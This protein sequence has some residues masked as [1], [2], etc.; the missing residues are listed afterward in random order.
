MLSHRQC[1]VGYGKFVRQF[2]FKL[3]LQEIGYQASTTLDA[4]EPTRPYALRELPK[5]DVDWN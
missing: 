4:S 3:C 2:R 5:A 1:L